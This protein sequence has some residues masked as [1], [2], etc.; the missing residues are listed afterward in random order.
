MTDEGGSALW[1]SATAAIGSIAKIGPS[2]E[3]ETSVS[4]VDFASIGSAVSDVLF[5]PVGIQLEQFIMYFLDRPVQHGRGPS[6]CHFNLPFRHYHSV[7]FDRSFKPIG[8]FR[9]LL[10]Q[11]SKRGLGRGTYVGKEGC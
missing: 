7:P 9:M 10:A 1:P 11:L 3:P 4:L 5:I 6:W 8:L 2:E